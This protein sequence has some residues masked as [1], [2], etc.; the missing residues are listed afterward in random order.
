MA[1][2]IEDGDGYDRG[3]WAASVEALRQAGVLDGGALR[4]LA[5]YHRPVIL[6][7]HGRAGRRGGARVRA[8]AGGRADRLIGSG[9]GRPRR[10]RVNRPTTMALDPDPY[11]IL[12]LPPGAT[13]DEVKRAYRRLAK[14]HHPDAAG[15]AALPRFLAIQ[16][17]YEQLLTGAPPGA[18]GR[19]AAG[20]PRR[21][22]EADPD[23]SDATR[24]AYGGRARSAPPGGATA[25][26]GGRARPSGPPGAGGGTEP[27]AAGAGRPRPGGTGR[28]AGRGRGAARAGSDGAAPGR[29]PGRPERPARARAGRRRAL[30]PTPGL[31]GRLGS[32]PGNAPESGRRPVAQDEAQQGDARID[33]L[34][35]RRRAVRARLGRRELVRDDERHVLDAQPEGVRRPAQARTG[36]PGT[37]QASGAGQAA[38]GRRDRRRAPDGRTGRIGRSRAARGRRTRSARSD[39]RDRPAGRPASRSRTRRPG[40]P[41]RR[42]RGGT[43]RPDRPPL[44]AAGPRTRTHSPPRP[45][46]S[47]DDRRRRARRAAATRPRSALAEDIVRALTDE[48]LG[49]V[50][51]RVVARRH[52]LAARSPSASAGSSAS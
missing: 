25:G 1:I 6:D 42:A 40:R 15:E 50:R 27:G 2:K 23:R 11:R 43:R 20:A 30:T 4:E 28:R 8:R 41:T 39:R 33:L 46:P 3:T 36:V 37:G 14:V 12:G 21:A 34:R 18:R 47:A 26:G 44:R 51:G 7:P 13:L 9:R 19:R 32:R 45:A 17:A 49:G 22:W 10:R 16:A 35:R 48:R 38:R 31:G 24:R 5:R 52:R 29:P